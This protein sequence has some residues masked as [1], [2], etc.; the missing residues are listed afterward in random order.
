MPSGVTKPSSTDRRKRL[1][2][3]IEQLGFPAMAP[4]P[5]CLESGSVCIIQKGST[6]CSCCVRKNIRCGGQFSDAEFDQLEAQKTDLLLKKMKARERLTTLAWELL[7]AQKEQELLDQK[8]SKIHDRQ[9][10]MIEQE[11]RALEEFDTFE[12][13]DDPL[14]LALMSEVDFSLSD[15]LLSWTG[16]VQRSSGPGPGVPNNPAGQSVNL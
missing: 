8:L 14:P 5:Q 3:R 12:G 16:E 11:A 7:A 15:D 4:C 6:R 9:E 1:A 13:R 10:K 2:C